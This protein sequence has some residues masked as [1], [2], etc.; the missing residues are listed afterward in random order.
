[1]ASIQPRYNK[2]GG[3]ISYQIKVSRGRDPLTRKQLTPYTTTWVP[4]EGWNKWSAR[5]KERELNKI[6]GEFEAACDRGEI[7]TRKEKKEVAISKAKEEQAAIT[8]LKYADMFLK[9]KEP[10][11]AINTKR[12]YETSLSRAR[13][14]FGNIRVKDIDLSMIKSFF[15]FLENEAKNEL[16]GKPLSHATILLIYRIL[17]SMFQNAFMDGVIPVNPMNRMKA[18]RKTK[19]DA[20]IM[21]K[22]YSEKEVNYIIKCLEKEHIKWRAL[23]MLLF[24]SGLRRGEALGLNW[25]DINFKTGEV[26][27]T[28]NV[29]QTEGGLLYITTPKSGKSR[30]IYLTETS[31]PVLKEWRKEQRELLFKLG[32]DN[33]DYCFTDIHGNRIRPTS[34]NNYFNRFAK[35]NKLKGFHPHTLRHTWASITIANGESKPKI[36][37]NIDSDF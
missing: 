10:E 4:P 37:T 29:Q 26:Q 15:T 9:E 5:R 36:V 12:S 24:D 18:P 28:K 19:E 34:L 13:A 14:Y 7:L 23:I 22:S 27:I 31:I 20:N 30:T 17:N 8:F 21:K 16:T 35:K 32:V 11:L 3:V 25:S 6:A 1:M 33:E 2:D